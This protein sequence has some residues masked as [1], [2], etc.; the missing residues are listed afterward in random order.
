MAAQ[1]L[2]LATEGE[3][4]DLSLKVLIKDRETC[5]EHYLAPVL[6]KGM[7]FSGASRQQMQPLRSHH[8]CRGLR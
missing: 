3:H 2:W 7:H 8:N 1:A 6:K 4:D 5:L